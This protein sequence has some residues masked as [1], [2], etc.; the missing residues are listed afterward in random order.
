M[1]KSLLTVFLTALILAL[2]VPI[3]LNV[4]Q[5]E[6]AFTQDNLIFIEDKSS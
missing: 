2:I 5:S 3:Y 6:P 1:K 4:L